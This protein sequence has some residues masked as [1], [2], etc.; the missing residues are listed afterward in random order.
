MSVDAQAL[1]RELH[2]A[3]AGEVRFGAGTR[4]L[5]TTGGSNYRQVPIGVVLPKTIDDVVATVEIC[6]A[7]D[8]PVLSR[9]GGTSL[10][11]QCCNVAVLIDHSK[12]L[13]H[14]VEIDSERKLA[15]VQ[16][17]VVLD[18][19][20][21]QA[22]SQYGLTFGP[23]PSTHDH[24]TF[25][26]MIGNNSCG[27]RSIMAQFSGTGPRTSDN[28]HELEVLLYDGRRLRVGAGSSGD[29]EIDRRLTELR[30]RHADQVRARYPDIPRRISGYNLDDLLPEK[31]FHVARALVGTES[32]CVTV[33]EATV[34]LLHS[35]R[36]R[37][38]L[39]LGFADKYRAA[40]HVMDVLEHQPTGLEGVDE[41]L[42]QDMKLVGIHDENLTMLPDGR[43]WLLAE[44]GGETKQESDARAHDCM[45]A[46]R[47]A[48]VD[49]KLY[50]DPE[51]E[52]HVWEVRE[53]GLG[54]TAFIPGKPDTYEGWEDS[55]VPPERLGEYLRR[56][57]KLAGQYDYESAVYGHYGNGCVHAR[58]NFD[59][60][61]R[62]GIEKFR[63]WLDDASDLVLELGGS[64][65]GE[66]GDG[67]SR[68]E[69]LPKMF[70][71][72]L[73]GAF[74][75][76][77]SI[78]DPQWKMNPGKVVDPYRITENLRLGTDYN[79][80]HVDAHFAFSDDGG[81]F[82]HA[83]TRCVGIGKCRRVEPAG[84]VMCP[85]YQ[86]TLEEKHT[87]RG[88][89]RI[90]WEML[91]GGELELW[92]SKEV[93]DALDLCLSCKGCTH[94]CPVSVDMP[95][96]KAEFLSHHYRGRF[97]PRHAYAF[98]LIDQAARFASKQ[99]VLA[100][101]LM[102]T[103]LA[104]LASGAHPKREFPPFAPLTLR[105]WFHSRDAP[106]ASSKKVILWADTFNNYFHTEVAVAAV[107]V[108]EAAGYSVEIPRKHVCCGR[109]LYDYGMLGLARR[110]L[111]RV[112]AELRDEIRAGTPI[113]GIEPS[114]IA[115]LKD[116]VAK[117]LP[118]EEDAKRLSKQSFH[119]AEFLCR[120]GY[121]P[122]DLHGRAIVHG[123]CHEKATAGFD[124]L[125]QVLEKMG[126]ELECPDSGCCG[127]AGAW[128]YETGHYDLSM[129]C[130]ERVLFP[131]VRA[132]GREPLIVTDGFSCKT[133]IE[134]GTGRRA[135]HLAE[136]LQLARGRSAERP[137]PSRTRKAARV[138]A[139][140][141]GVLALAAGGLVLRGD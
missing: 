55:A 8:A 98:G 76:F 15:R 54:A 123:H 85:S 48:A 4:A 91:N 23:D 53:A 140:A 128:G 12:Y 31:G 104:K 135:L 100:N 39:V 18:Q 119:L 73:V 60:V 107:E 61:T 132:A 99:P 16:P 87:T 32:T 78:W 11:G 44:F 115:V 81:S 138:G 42:V 108:L 27:V 2:G 82:A 26:G 24:C 29:P 72:E 69:L 34:H 68:A 124:P 109:P 141:A 94:D 79:P 41:I 28:V 38:L 66:H 20:R 19:L 56:L 133:Q 121:E 49:M 77:K 117:M 120:E 122:P 10:A 84:G 136:V 125:T 63:R 110:Y 129:A 112:L 65:S 113:V 51:Q 86:V 62:E 57:D 3:L 80:P 114:C 46:L 134:H 6:R 70:G 139:V 96:L 9:G 50:D 43:G 33:L 137:Q 97:R 37:S 127:M 47:G 59:L 93:Y 103:P 13:R 89:A 118:K 58:W 52:Q 21:K 64:L 126:L 7:H 83:T 101:A 40:D 92:R 25:G 36:C 74:R 95:T 1:A 102:R 116:E 111:E 14:I 17:G 30:D 22:E 71:D 131:A 88:R 45:D 5:Y 105:D 67:Q 75:E 130:G 106:S 90:L 35:P